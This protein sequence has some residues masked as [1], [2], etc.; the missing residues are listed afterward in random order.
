MKTTLRHITLL[1]VILT[2][3]ACHHRS[4]NE[5]LTFTIEGTLG[6]ASNRMLYI[7]EITPDNG[8]QFVDSLPCDRDGHFRFKGSM[9]YPTFYSVN[10]SADNCVVLL[11]ADGEEITLS[12]DANSLATTYRVQGSPESQLMWQLQSY[13]NQAKQDIAD[14]AQQDRQN[15]ATMSDAEYERAHAASDSIFLA[16]R[17]VTY[18][19]FCNFIADNAGS[20]STL[21]AIDAPY[22]LTGRVFYAENDFDIFEEVLAGLQ[23]R[24]P[25]NPHTQFFQTRVERERS[26]R[27]LMQ[28]QQQEGQGII[29]E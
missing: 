26:A 11:P 4:G 19:M 13:I 29:I 8:A 6:N 14:L 17:Q 25:D 15:R 16:Q 2:L 18:L 5:A 21:F 1:I 23:E 24:Y 28:Q 7:E 3:A 20:L 10:V 22:N 27:M 12:G 9:S